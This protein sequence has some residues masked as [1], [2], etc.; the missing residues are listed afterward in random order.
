MNGLLGPPP[1]SIGGLG[2]SLSSAILGSLL[3]IRFREPIV[4]FTNGG[5][6]A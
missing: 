3:S 1:R 5:G 4:R 6:A 2:T